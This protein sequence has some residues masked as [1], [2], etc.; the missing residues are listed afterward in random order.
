MRFFVKNQCCLFTFPNHQK[1]ARFSC[2]GEAVAFNLRIGLNF[3][4]TV[5]AT[6]GKYEEHAA[7]STF[8]SCPQSDKP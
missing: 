7:L 2:K 1:I 6:A 3:F 4:I 5:M 8:R